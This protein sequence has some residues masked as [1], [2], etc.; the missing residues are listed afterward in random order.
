MH[1]F[2][3]FFDVRGFGN[4]DRRV[5]DPESEI[6]PWRKQYRKIIDDF[7]KKTGYFIKRTGDGIVIFQETDP[8]DAWYDGANFL[9]NCHGFMLLM[10]DLN[11]KKK[12]PRPDGVR[13][14]CSYGAVWKEPCRQLGKDY[15]GY[16][17]NLT[18]RMLHQHKE[19]C[20]IITE[21]LKEQLK[22]AQCKKMGFC[23]KHA[24]ID[25]SIQVDSIY[26][27]DLRLQW[28]FWKRRR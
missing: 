13:F 27:A 23:F 10:K 5:T 22:N 3:G 17:V 9:E 12:S 26:E 8:N 28:L 25:S 1:C 15:F 11:K 21:S 14:R 7:E 24:G 16:K 6:L 2:I 19:A 4:F 20:F 18:E